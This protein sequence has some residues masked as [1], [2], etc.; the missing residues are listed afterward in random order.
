M[1]GIS[2]F[3]A[4]HIARPLVELT[5]VTE[6]IG[7]GRLKSRVRL[8]RHLRGEAG[9]LA[10]AVNDMAARIEKQLG[11]QRELLA[12]VS[13]EIRS[14]LARM[15]VLLELL[16]E[17]HTDAAELDKLE[18]ELLDIDRLVGDLLASSRLE[19][20]ALNESV[21][22]AHDVALHALERAGLDAALLADDALGARF[23]GDPTLVGRA[24]ENLL[25]NAKTHGRGVESLRVRTQNG[26]IAFE[27]SDRGPGFSAEMLR[28][29][30]QAF[31]K[32]GH[33][34]ASSLGLGLALVR[35]IAR[36]HGGDAWA[37]NREQGGALV[38]FRLRAVAAGSS[39]RPG[40]SNG[41]AD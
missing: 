12:A 40:E 5:R 11:D 37:E 33:A 34:S 28:D 36:A 19:F 1:W 38:A 30:F 7:A 32:D 22:S 13:H 24:L 27:V 39:V 16:R 4:R 21:L 10:E 23:A 17:R 35:R 20:S 14:P 8:G 41:Q 9:M 29:G 15:R 25:D 2:G 3:V 31:K 18:R 26:D 6:E